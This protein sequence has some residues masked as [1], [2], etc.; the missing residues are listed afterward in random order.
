MAKRL[1]ADVHGMLEL[2]VEIL[3]GRLG[4]LVLSRVGEDD[5][6][7]YADYN[8]IKPLCLCLKLVFKKKDFFI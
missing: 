8:I 6:N 4:I 3:Y 1:F 5:L 7:A 2:M